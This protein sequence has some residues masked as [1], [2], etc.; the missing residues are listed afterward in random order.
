MTCSCSH[1]IKESIL[2]KFNYSVKEGWFAEI[3]KYHIL[4]KTHFELD[5]EFDE[6]NGF[7]Y[8]LRIFADG[9]LICS[10][11]TSFDPRKEDEKHIVKAEEADCLLGKYKNLDYKIF[12]DFWIKSEIF[13]KTC[14]RLKPSSS[15]GTSDDYVYSVSQILL[16]IFDYTQ[17]VFL[18]SAN[19]GKLRNLTE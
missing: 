4:E 15:Y 2:E 10:W 1:S 19:C 7:I 8:T 18:L 16:F 17:A 13:L 9:L 5:D 11:T 6:L 12:N 14:F 3:D